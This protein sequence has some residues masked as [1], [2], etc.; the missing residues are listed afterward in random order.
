MQTRKY[1]KWFKLLSQ[2]IINLVIISNSTWRHGIWR[3]EN[4]I[5]TP[6]S[7]F[8]DRHPSSQPS[9]NLNVSLLMILLLTNLLWRPNNPTT[10]LLELLAELTQIILDTSMKSCLTSTDTFL[11]PNKNKGFL[12]VQWIPHSGQQMLRL[13]NTIFSFNKELWTEWK[14]CC[15][16][17]YL[18]LW[19]MTSYYSCQKLIFQLIG[20]AKTGIRQYAE[21]CIL[22]WKKNV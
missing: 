18:C 9:T 16:L 17:F 20:Q 7:G 11:L 3:M 21:N 2:R 12:K 1:Q 10:R 13:K 15:C 22:F 14:I 6:F 5:S 4:P 19:Q 8:W